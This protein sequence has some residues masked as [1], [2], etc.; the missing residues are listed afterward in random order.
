MGQR[1]STAVNR[2]TQAYQQAHR[3]RV[4]PGNEAGFGRGRAQAQGALPDQRDAG[5]QLFL[6]QKGGPTEM[7]PDLVKFLQDVGPLKKRGTGSVKKDKKP[8]TPQQS[9]PTE[10]MSAADPPSGRTRQ[11]MRLASAVEGFDTERTTNF[12]YTNAIEADGVDVLGMYRLLV[13]AGPTTTDASTKNITMDSSLENVAR[14]VA[15]TRT[16]IDVPLIVRDSDDSLVGIHPQKLEEV[17]LPIV[18][19]TRVKLVF[20]DLVELQAKH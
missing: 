19:K 3:A 6:Q 2:A 17:N 16:F 11:A 15:D 14:L 12:S 1:V 7:P 13:A 9:V 4:E 5:Q 20:E 10:D 18:P 8:K